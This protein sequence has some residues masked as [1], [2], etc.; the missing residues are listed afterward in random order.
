MKRLLGTLV[1]R[2]VFVTLGAVAAGT[3]VW[4]LGPLATLGGAR[5]LAGEVARW[6]AIGVLAFAAAAYA[7]SRAAGSARRNRRLMDGLVAGGG[8]PAAAPGAHDLAVIGRRFEE[9][10]ALLRRTR[11]GG[12]RALLG[13]L[14]GRPLV[15]QLPW[16]VIIGA[17]GAGKTTALVNSGLD[18]PLASRLGKTPVRGVGGTRN[19]DWWFAS[20]AV[21]LD[22]AGRFTTQD[23]D[24]E[25]DRAA[26][27]GFLDLLVRYRP[28]RPINGVLATI[29]V[30]DLLAASAEDRL[31]HA[32][33]L[34]ERIDELHAR[35]GTGIPIYVLVTKVDL[36]AGFMEFFADFDKDERA[37]VWGV[38]FPYAPD[39]AQAD[40]MARVDGEL[41]ALEK[42]L[43]ECLIDR[44]YEEQ[45]R[46]KRAAIYAFPQQWRVLR[47]TLAAF[48]QT[49][50]AAARPDARPLVRGVYFTSATQEGTPMDRALGGLARALGLQSRIVPAARPSGKTFFVTR[51]LRDVVFAEAG[52]AGTNLRWRRGRAWLE[53]AAM[54]AAVVGVVATVALLARTYADNRAH[55]AAL[56]D[57]LQS[58]GRAVTL[59]KDS[60][61]TNLVALVAP[62]DALQV[63]GATPRAPSAAP[64]PDRAGLLRLR[65]MGLDQSTMLTAA[66]QD[67]YLRVLREAF[68]PRI[69]ARLEER[70][71]SGGEEHV[72]M[73]YEAL[74][75]YLMLFG[76][77]NFD[78]ASLRGY[79]F[80]DWEAT[81]PQTV[82][83]AER[84]ALRR[85]LDHLLGSGEVGA[86]SLADQQVIDR[87][88][89][90]VAGVP[91]ARRVYSRLR[92]LD[93]GPAAPAFTVA[94]AGGPAA[95]QVFTRASGQPLTLGVP[96]LYSRAV[97]QDSFR[98][99]SLDVLRQF[100][101]ESGWVLGA[102]AAGAPEAMGAALRGEIE[103]LYLA[104][105]ARLWNEFVGDLRLVRADSL[106]GN[107]LL[108][109]V[110]ARADSPLASLLTGIA[111]EVS[112]APRVEAPA[113]AATRAVE[114]G[115][116]PVADRFAD[117]TRF[118]SGQPSTLQD[119]LGLL[120]KLA[121]HLTAV[122]DAVKR[123]LAP[124]PSDVTR[125]LAVLA[126]RAPEPVRGM[127]QQLASTSAGQV[128][129]ARRDEL[130]RLIASEVG[131]PCARLVEGRYPL[132]RGQREV[133]RDE[134]AVTEFARVFGAGGV[135]DGFFQ[136]QL[137]PYVDTSG[138]V[139]ALYRPDGRTEAAESLQ[140]FQR[141]LAIRDAFFSDGGKTL[142]GRLEFRLL[143]MQTGVGSMVL[144]VDGQVLKF[145]RDARAPQAVRWPGPNAATGSGRVQLRMFTTVPGASE[146]YP[147]D[148]PW[149]LFRL[150]DRVRTEPGP[151]A[152]RVVL[153][154][155]V[156]GRKARFEVRS[157]NSP[158]PLRP[159]GVEPFRCPQ[160]L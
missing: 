10:I 5:P 140:V 122:E 141:A 2:P 94:S 1:S 27:F 145:T 152:D 156:E 73:I 137:A 60:A 86:P 149:A 12:R 100:A 18:F 37:Q 154:F 102:P 157:S 114:A 26:W 87:A 38:T 95:A 59:A 159:T 14:L 61:P 69:A 32:R 81:L 106:A 126:T 79:L 16:Y 104:D 57:R 78:A 99:R 50:F 62:L 101:D 41:A 35:L 111:R 75:A 63:L 147:Y 160:R 45:D 49:S 120:G 85:H 9:A 136:R 46:E 36:L 80:A 90:L 82:D 22:T 143:E 77:R 47:E 71:R 121:A 105:Y 88:R 56:T 119:A 48:L 150:L 15:Y 146:L 19:C 20:D 23:S 17:P 89:K 66:A 42:R 3:L 96:G 51:L 91:L 84:E 116:S 153:T 70:L 65:S 74:K 11:L 129:A 103:Q 64:A 108:A 117:L 110:L 53:W 6:A 127:L 155:D 83:A 112:V 97:L 68:Q 115:R 43:D 151:S 124:P 24:R 25:A 93:L 8:A 58:L 107:A 118:V 109:Q 72:E 131:A 98:T 67:T 158:N 30:T 39:T 13:A 44:L 33:K 21:L 40:P 54:A 125:E 144:D 123:R 29:S 142:G 132:V 138:A 4:F 7:V 113:G 92:S 76:G 148:G 28:R 134:I 55:V 31:V 52:L 133:V 34:R 128:L 135:F 130:N 139:W